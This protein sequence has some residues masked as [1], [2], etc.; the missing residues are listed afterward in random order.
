MISKILKTKSLSRAM[1]SSAAKKT[2][3][4]EVI[5]IGKIS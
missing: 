4:A 5:K 2:E 3:G 1:F